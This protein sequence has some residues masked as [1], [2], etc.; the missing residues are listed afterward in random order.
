MIDYDRGSEIL[1]LYDN[2]GK[3][4]HIASYKSDASEFRQK[5]TT[6]LLFTINSIYFIKKGK[7]S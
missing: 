1:A 5:K 4:H 7:K 3:P 6:L 2:H